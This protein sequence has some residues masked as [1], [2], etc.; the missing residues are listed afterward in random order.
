MRLPCT[1]ILYFSVIYKNE[2]FNRK[3]QKSNNELGLINLNR[4]TT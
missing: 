4:L 3:F 1:V 2:K